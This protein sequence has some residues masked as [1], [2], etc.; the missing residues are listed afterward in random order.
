M[1]S[2]IIVDYY[3]DPDELKQHVLIEDPVKIVFDDIS[4]LKELHILSKT[5]IKMAENHVPFYFD[6]ILAES[7]ID[8]K[9]AHGVE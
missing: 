7:L 3:V 2:R 9:I 5:G 1:T 6:R 8:Q 4:R